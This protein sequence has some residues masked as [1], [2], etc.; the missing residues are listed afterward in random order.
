M[1]NITPNRPPVHAVCTRIW[2]KLPMA[3]TSDLQR[4]AHRKPAM[5]SARREDGQ[6][7]DSHADRAEVTSPAPS[8]PAILQQQAAAVCRQLRTLLHD[9]SLRAEPQLRLELAD[10]LLQEIET[11]ALA[12]HRPAVRQAS[13]RVRRA[14]GLPLHG[15]PVVPMSVETALAFLS[16]AIDPPGEMV[17]DVE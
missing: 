15:I 2:P 8:R 6:S 12:L 13:A 4:A 3:K 7:S 17:D 1:T 5:T 9:A 10:E 16:L 11:V 14:I